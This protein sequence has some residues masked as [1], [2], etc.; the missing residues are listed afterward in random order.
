MPP[1]LF[2]A[3]HTAIRKGTESPNALTGDA[4][5]K[6]GFVHDKGHEPPGHF[7]CL[8]AFMRWPLVWP[9]GGARVVEVP[10]ELPQDFQ[11]C[12]LDVTI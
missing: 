7:V 6:I 5:R 9:L 3:Q 2:W 8:Q 1:P 4:D 12:Q 11:R 10:L